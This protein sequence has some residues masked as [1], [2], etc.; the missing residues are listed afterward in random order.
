MMATPK[1]RIEFSWLLPTP[2]KTLLSVLK[3]KIQGENTPK[4]NFHFLYIFFLK[5]KGNINRAGRQLSVWQ[6]DPHLHGTTAAQLLSHLPAPCRSKFSSC[7]THHNKGR[8]NFLHQNWV[9]VVRPKPGPL[10]LSDTANTKLAI[11]YME[12]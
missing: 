8:L 2:R 7:C 1:K 6:A 4:N 9:L 5:K 10:E 12:L 3:S 11:L